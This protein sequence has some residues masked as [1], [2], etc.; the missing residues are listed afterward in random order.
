M[1]SFKLKSSW[2]TILQWVEFSIFPLILA[3]ALQQRSATALPEIMPTGYFWCS[4]CISA[5]IRISAASSRSKQNPNLQRVRTKPNSNLAI[6]RS[7]RT[8]PD[9][10]LETWVRFPSLLCARPPVR[11][12]NMRPVSVFNFM[13]TAIT[14]VT[15]N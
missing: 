6:S 14:A 4:H 8:E 10:N 12:I 5:F 11:H 9:P 3:W 1:P 2:V 13:F 7:C 15:A